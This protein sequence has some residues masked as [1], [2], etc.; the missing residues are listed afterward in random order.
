[1]SVHPSVSIHPSNPPEASQ[2]PTW[3]LQTLN[4]YCQVSKLPSQAQNHPFWAGA[5]EG[6]AT[7][8]STQGNFS[9]LLIPPH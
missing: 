8:D 6:Q 7:N 3:P 9:V 2:A 5:K 4:Q 1:M